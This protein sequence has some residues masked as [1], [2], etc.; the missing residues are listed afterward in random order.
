MR[1]STRLARSA[2][3]HLPPAPYGSRPRL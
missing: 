1:L 3:P 2:S